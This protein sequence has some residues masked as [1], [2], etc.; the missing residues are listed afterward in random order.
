MIAGEIVLNDKSTVRVLIKPLLALCLLISH[1]VQVMCRST[2]TV[3]EDLV[4]KV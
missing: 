3:R 4:Y 1:W 2:V